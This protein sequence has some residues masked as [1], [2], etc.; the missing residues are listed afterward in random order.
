MLT[1]VTDHNFFGIMT[2]VILAKEKIY[3]FSH[4]DIS[5]VFFRYTKKEFRTVKRLVLI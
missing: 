1:E 2:S 4:Y 3:L 5:R